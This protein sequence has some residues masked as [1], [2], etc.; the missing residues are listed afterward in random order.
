[1]KNWAYLKTTLAV[2]VIL[3]IATFEFVSTR[4]S[5]ATSEKHAVLHKHAHPY[6]AKAKGGGQLEVTLTS[7]IASPI[8]VDSTFTLSA[9]I[10][11]TS[12]LDGLKYEWLLPEGVTV[13]GGVLTG[14]IGGLEN[15]ASHD[16]AIQLVSATADNRQ[17][18]LHVYRVV[19]GE[20]VG[21]MAQFNTRDQSKIAEDVRAKVETLSAATTRAPAS[22][23]RKLMQ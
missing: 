3:G 6:G 7:D 2:L 11:A 12:S 9:Q 10:V 15:G 23:R 17:V 4:S 22:E 21:H 19:G 8:P 14:D 20:P 18:Q 5:E 1:M 16:L 13:K